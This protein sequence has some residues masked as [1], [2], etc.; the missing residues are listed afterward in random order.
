M[1]FIKLFSLTADAK[2]SEIENVNIIIDNIYIC[3]FIF[4]LSFLSFIPSFCVSS[5]L[6]SS[7]R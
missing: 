2:K 4:E 5:F 6:P 1:Y 7:I 3:A